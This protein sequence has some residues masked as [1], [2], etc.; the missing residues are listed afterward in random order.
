MIAVIT[1]KETGLHVRTIKDLK[2]VY[3]DPQRD[4]LILTYYDDQGVYQQYHASCS[5]KADRPLKIS[6]E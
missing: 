3:A 5:P 2:H 4:L 6:F 1:D